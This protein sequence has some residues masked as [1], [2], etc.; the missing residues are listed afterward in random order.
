M[1]GGPA[2]RKCCTPR[3]TFSVPLPHFVVQTI[4]LV[5][6]ILTNSLVIM[7]TILDKELHTVPNIGISSLALAD[8]LLAIAWFIIQLLVFRHSISLTGIDRNLRHIQD[9]AFV[10][11]MSVIL[12]ILCITIDRYIAMVHPLYHYKVFN[13][14][15]FSTWKVV[16]LCVSVWAAAAFL[17]YTR[18]FSKEW[19]YC[20]MSVVM[21]MMRT[22]LPLMVT[23]VLNIIIFITIRNKTLLRVTMEAQVST[24]LDNPSNNPSKH[25]MFLRNWKA[26]KTISLILISIVLSY[27]P[28]SLITMV[29]VCGAMPGLY[30]RMS[31][32]IVLLK[33]L[34]SITNPTIYMLT[35]RQFKHSVKTYLGQDR[36]TLHSADRN[37]NHDSR[38]AGGRKISLTAS[39]SC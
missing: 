7:V 18:R 11:E 8:L 5:V 1:C 21:N 10:F 39:T 23:A 26:F 27:V 22:I 15:T 28:L 3:G 2:P 29:S 12:H 34:N 31:N 32:Y 16:A 37:T 19:T 17:A 4:L 25:N 13:Y 35:T 30:E 36:L 24:T 20:Y 14:N 9:L 38:E 6:I 33:F